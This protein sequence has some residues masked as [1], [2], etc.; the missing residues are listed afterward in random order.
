MADRPIPLPPRTPTPPP[1]DPLG[2]FS[3]SPT[4][5]V[6]DSSALSPLEENFSTSRNGPMPTFLTTTVSLAES[7]P[8][9]MHTPISLDSN[10]SSRLNDGRKPSLMV[11]DA[12]G[13]FNFQPASMA[14]APVNA[15]SVCTPAPS[16]IEEQQA[17]MEYSEHWAAPGP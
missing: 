2:G 17:D 5:S 10:G 13:V 15:K 9:A 1:D 3:N 14:K 7:D 11:E 8:N 6:Y 4:K 16:L 12:N